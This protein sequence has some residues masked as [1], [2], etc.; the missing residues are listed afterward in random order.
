MKNQPV[1]SS[2]GT[3]EDIV[4]E[5][6]NKA[7]GAY[8]LNQQ[9]RKYLIIAF[10]VSLLGVSSAIAVPFIK[11]FKSES[12]PI[13]LTTGGK[14][15]LTP[16]DNELDPRL[17]VP[18]PPPAEGIEQMVYTA[19]LVV[20]DAPD[21]EGVL[22]FEDLLE[23]VRNAPVDSMPLIV[24][25]PTEPTGIDEKPEAI[26]L[27]PQERA[28]FLGGTE[29]D[30]RIWLI[31]NMVYPIKA[32]ELN[33]FGKVIVQFCV[34]S[35]GKIVDIQFVR[36]LDPLVDNEVL[37]VLSSSPDWVPAKQGGIPVKTSFTI[38]VLFQMQ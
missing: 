20:E 16:I 27:F 8:D 22:I 14:A 17:V 12:G 2:S 32:A 34:N 38:P 6:R 36:S 10:L 3:I 9:R 19:P 33:I 35:K 13:L 7:Y 26:V 37:R 11:A 15:E 24:E 29:E 5:H 28:S 21:D 23:T 4:F 31:N 1:F 18:P 30:F 25:K